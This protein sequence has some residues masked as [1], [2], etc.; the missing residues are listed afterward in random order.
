MSPHPLLADKPSAKTPRTGRP[1]LPHLHLAY[2]VF[3]FLGGIVF[4]ALNGFSPEES[5]GD[6]VTSYFFPL[7]PLVLRCRVLIAR[8]EKQNPVGWISLAIGVAGLGPVFPAGYSRF[9]L[10][11]PGLAAFRAAERLDGGVGLGRVGGRRRG[12]P[13]TG[14]PGRQ[15]A[16]RQ[17]EARSLA[18]GGG[19]GDAFAAVAFKPGRFEFNPTGRKPVRVGRRRGFFSI[20]C[21]AG[22]I[23]LVMA[24][25]VASTSLILSFIRSDGE[26][27]VQIKWLISAGS[28]VVMSHP[29]AR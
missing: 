20:C 27:R 29:R 8:K 10:I 6:S 16:L 18:G 4:A 21:A 14:L 22:V 7:V 25:L 28:S 11:T 3:L 1:R 9:A 2:A 26:L 23:L 13:R 12:L 15:A 17:L 19:G 24:V 5:W